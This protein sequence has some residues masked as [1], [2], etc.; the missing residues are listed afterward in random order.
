MLMLKIW[1]KKKTSLTNGIY[2][3]KINL[4]QFLKSINVFYH[5]NSLKKEKHMIISIDA[6]KVFI[7][8]QHPQMIKTLSGI[9]EGNSSNW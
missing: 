2:P 8:C 3:G 1:W 7:K 6:E 5:T 9:R 4:I